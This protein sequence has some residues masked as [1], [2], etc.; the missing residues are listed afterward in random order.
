M[1]VDTSALLAIL[2]REPE[3]ESFLD[4]MMDESSSVSAATLVEAHLVVRGRR[5]AAA[6]E[7]LEVLLED[8][9]VRVAPVDEQIARIAI[10]AHVRFGRGSGHPARLNYGDCFSYALAVSRDESLLCK[11]DD[12][13]HTDVRLSVP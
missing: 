10:E 3:G 12:F 11:G 9:E 4:R 8:A 5:G 7:E 1:I 13:V 6:A 2:F